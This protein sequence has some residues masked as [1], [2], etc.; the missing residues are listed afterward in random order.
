MGDLTLMLVFCKLG[1]SFEKII[2]YGA[3]AFTFE[4]AMTQGR[5]AHEFSGN[6]AA[7][8]SGTERHFYRFAVSLAHRGEIDCN[9]P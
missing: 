6:G 5:P 3:F 8:Q 4:F 9:L 1:R 7:A 2:Q